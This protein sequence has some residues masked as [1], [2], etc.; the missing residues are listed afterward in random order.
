[1]CR[2]EL[3]HGGRVLASDSQEF[4]SD[5]S[6]STFHVH[7]ANPVQIEVGQIEIEVQ[8][9]VSRIEMEVQLEVSLKEIEVQVE[10]N[11]GGPAHF[12]SVRYVQM[13]FV[14]IVFVRNLTNSDRL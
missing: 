7:F 6:S 13:L 5:G 14:I 10:V 12:D 3:K 9:E 2:M 4:Q 11:R 1:M 8:L